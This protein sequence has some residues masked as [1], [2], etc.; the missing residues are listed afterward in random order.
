MRVKRWLSV[1]SILFF[2]GAISCTWEQMEPQIDCL[3]NP[4]IIEL[5]ESQDA[6]CGASNGSFTV[7]VSG[8]EGPYEYDS[9]LGNNSDG[10]FINAKAGS[11]VLTV[12]D[13]IGCSAELSIPIQNLGGLNL[14]EVVTSDSGCDSAN[15]TIHIT[16]SG[17]EEPYQFSI[18]GGN[19]Q[20]SN[21]FSDLTQ[22]D[23]AVSVRDQVGC[24]ITKSVA[25]QSGI[26]FEN[27]VKSII[28]NSCA[29]P[30]CHNGSVSP[31]LRSFS[32]IQS[33]ANSIKSRTA[34]G[35]MPRG[36]TLSQEQ[37]ELIACWVDDGALEN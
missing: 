28:E 34:N 15:G 27:S 12:T 16:A 17:G 37:I 32:N 18:N 29:I 23:Y 20:T 14:E 5:L 33:R 11:Y 10:V 30:G 7:N 6:E 4:I 22:G 13:A 9:E 21:V 19:P 1:I 24:E 26:S 36:S 3:T 25:V 8:G 31:D 35:S 2:L